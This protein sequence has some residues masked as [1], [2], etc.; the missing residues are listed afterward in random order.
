MVEPANEIDENDVFNIMITTD[1]HL[2][3]KENDKVRHSDSFYSFQESLKIAS[4]T[5]NVDFVLMGGDLF[6]DHKP[7][8]KTFWKCQ[9]LFN[10]AVFG[11]QDIQF[12]TY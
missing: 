9:Q 11:E 6:H 7:S 4:S 12:E 3:Y 10:D 1:N 5:P 2:G 8:R